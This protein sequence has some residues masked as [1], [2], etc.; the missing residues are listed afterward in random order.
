[1]KHLKK[2]FPKWKLTY[3]CFTK[4]NT[5]ACENIQYKRHF[6]RASRANKFTAVLFKSSCQRFVWQERRRIAALE[7]ENLLEGFALSKSDTNIAF[8][9]ITSELYKVDLDETKKE[10]TP[11]FVRLDGTK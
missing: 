11:T 5:T 4:R 8:D 10:H 1:M 7:K 9:N 2:R 3:N 6:Q